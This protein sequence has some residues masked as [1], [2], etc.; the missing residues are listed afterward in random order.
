MEQV[1]AVAGATGDLGKRIVR[2]LV[3][4]G[5]NVRALVRP[6]ASV[7]QQ[8]ELKSLGARLGIA[9]PMNIIEMRQA[10]LGASCVVSALNGLRDV[11]IDRQTV[12]LNA[13]VEAKVPR[14]IPSDYSAEFRGVA[15]GTNRNLE[16]RQ[17]FM[18]TASA[19]PLEV[20]SVLNGAF[21]DMLGAEMPIIQPKVR[22]VLYW[23]SADQ[24]LDFTTKDDVAAYVAAVATD[25][26]PTPRWLRVAGETTTAKQLAATVTEVSG[27]T[28]KPQWAGNMTTLGAM[29]SVAKLAAGD[30]EEVFPAY[31]GMQ[32]MR[33]MFSGRGKLTPLDTDRYPELDWTGIAEMMRGKGFGGIT[34]PW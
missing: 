24:S 22:R 1:I 10:L 28:Y 5:A 3:S 14:F 15:R 18:L 16:L 6:N 23:G 34:K 31:Q 9:N 25:A 19:A 12:L 26:N 13:A 29:I 7:A 27:Q 4:R 21:M 30:T 32:Y 2:A 17:E 8:A 11:I 20:T 33:D